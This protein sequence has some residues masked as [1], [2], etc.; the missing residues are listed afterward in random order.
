M[1][2]QRPRSR[3]FSILA[4]PAPGPGGKANASVH[5]QVFLAGLFAITAIGTALLATPWVT[6]DGSRTSLIDAF[7][8][9]VS[10]ASVSGLAV[11]DTLEHWNLAGQIVV[12]ALVQIGGLGFMV[13][14]NILL[15]M[16][17]RGVGSYTLRDELLLRDGAPTLSINEAVSL[18]RHIFWFMLVV[19]AAG[20]VCLTL[21][22]LLIAKLPVMEA[23][24]QGIF[25]SIT[26]FCNAGFDVSRVA[27]HTDPATDPILNILLIVL[28]QLGAISFMVCKDVY[29]KRTW[30]S[31]S[32]DSKIV[33]GLNGALLLVGTLVFLATEWGEALEDVPVASKALVSLF[34]SASARSAGFNSVDWSLVNPL[35][36]FFWLGLMFIGGASG[37]T[38]GGV[39][40]NT[41]GVVL[42]AVASTLRGNP[43]TQLWGRRIAAPLVNRAITVIVIFLLIYGLGAAGLSA[44]E[45]QFSHRETPMIE[46]MF[47]AMSALATVGLSTGITPGLTAV[48]KVVLCGLMFVGHLGPLVTVYALQRRQ[49]P[50]RYR[51]PEEAV[52]IG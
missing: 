42:A 25:Y 27:P 7:F 9:A 11:V 17:R 36:L 34:Q 26:A 29:H 24:W 44:A 5:A 12:L 1:N 13:G 6:A 38:S 15:Q 43:E 48:S 14:A 47:E 35:T 23:V 49:R 21:W 39:R 51:F 8:T 16:L 32:L 50:H 18:A 40:L 45:H 52:H 28:I 2:P 33:L 3:F 30:R 46:L 22:F 37:S 10:A 19:E 31:L 20:A 41:A 4:P